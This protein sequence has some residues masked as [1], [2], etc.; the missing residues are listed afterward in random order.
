MNLPVFPPTEP[1]VL[2]DVVADE[3]GYY[4]AAGPKEI[5]GAAWYAAALQRSLSDAPDFLEPVLPPEAR[6]YV[7]TFERYLLAR[8][9]QYMAQWGAYPPRGAR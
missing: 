8:A 5:S 7:E 4:L 9:E 2:P 6:P 1:R 3:N